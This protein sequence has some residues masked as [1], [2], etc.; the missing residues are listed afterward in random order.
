MTFIAKI[1]KYFNNKLNRDLITPEI[2]FFERLSRFMH[3]SF[4]IL[5]TNKY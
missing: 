4:V 5:V 2:F 1:S 3:C